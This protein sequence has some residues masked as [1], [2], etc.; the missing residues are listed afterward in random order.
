MARAHR[1]PGGEETVHYASI[2]KRRGRPKAKIQPPLTPMIDVTFQLLLFFLLAATFRSESNI[3]GSIPKQGALTGPPTVEIM[4]VEVIVRQRGIGQ[5]STPV[6]GVKVQAIAMLDVADD[7]SV[8]RQRETAAKQ[9]YEELKKRHAAAG[10]P[11][12]P[13]IIRP[14]VD[15]ERVAAGE[16]QYVRWQYVAEAYNQAVRAG[17]KEIGFRWPGATGAGG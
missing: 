5:D 11:K 13:A 15:L 10:D 8:P 7:L 9:L 17:F 2:R 3:P 12:V 4:P 1:H 14:E 6:Y 16:Y